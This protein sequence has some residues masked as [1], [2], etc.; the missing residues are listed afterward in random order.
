MKKII[1]IFVFF[2][3]ISPVN[4]ADESPYGNYDGETIFE[5]T[6]NDAR[7]GDASAQYKICNFYYN[8]KGVQKSYEMAFEWCYKA[9]KLNHPSAL[10]FVGGMYAVGEGVK[11]NREEAQSWFRRAANLGNGTALYNL[12]D[13]YSVYRKYDISYALFSL[14]MERGEKKLAEAARDIDI[15]E[16]SEQ[17]IKSGK[18]LAEKLKTSKNFLK[19]LDEYENLNYS[20]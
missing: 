12:G 6:M 7:A 17:K 5:L 4:Y 20:K 15:P 3:V 2:S 16:M 18:T 11:E 9:A 8:G 1:F 19:T 10:A 14:A 13:M